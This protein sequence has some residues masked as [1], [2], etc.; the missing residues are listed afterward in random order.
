MK[1]NKAKEKSITK[2]NTA[3]KREKVQR[4]LTL[5]IYVTGPNVEHVATHKI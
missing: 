2:K 3:N 4:I 5:K 1:T